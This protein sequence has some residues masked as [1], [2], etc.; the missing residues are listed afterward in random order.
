MSPAAYAAEAAASYAASVGYTVFVN[1]MPDQPDNVI[2]FYDT[3]TGRTEERLHRSGEVEEH[4]GV[5]AIVRGKT[6]ATYDV[7]ANLWPVFQN[8]YMRVMSDTKILRSITKSNTIGSLGHE[9]QTR[10]CLY[11]QQFRMTL[12]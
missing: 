11:S 9:L 2:V 3:G 12:E 8:L 7:L 6:H 1:H 4:P 5:Q 10:R